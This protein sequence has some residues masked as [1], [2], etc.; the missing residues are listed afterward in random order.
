MRRDDFIRSPAIA[1]AFE[2]VPRHLFLPDLPLEQAYQ[3][4]AIPTR[5][6]ATG[7]VI[8]SSSQPQIMALMLEQLDLQP[9]HRV[10]EIGAGTGYNAA[11]MAYLAGE[12]GRVVTVDLDEEIVE[13]A[14]A[15]LAATGYTNVGLYCGDGWEGLAQE[16]PYDRIIVTASSMDIAPAWHDQLAP[17]GRIVLPLHLTSTTTACA[18]FDIRE[19]HLSSISLAYC[20]F[21][22]LRGELAPQLEVQEVTLEPLPGLT[23]VSSAPLPVPP[24][25][26]YEWLREGCSHQPTSVQTSFQT[27][28]A[29]LSLWVALHE[30]GAWVG[31]GTGEAMNSKLV[32]WLARHEGE[33]SISLTWG[34]VEEEGLALVALPPAAPPLQLFGAGTEP[35]MLWVYSCGPDSRVGQ[36]L[37]RQIMAWDAAGQPGLE[38]LMIRAY[39]RAAPLDVAP[40]AVIVE[41]PAHRF[42]LEWSS[43]T[44]GGTGEPIDNS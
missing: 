10:L 33:P 11:L 36:R 6:S 3:N 28:W 30:S 32:P 27:M 43:G 38:H 29:N 8:S 44:P 42:L 31:R 21:M 1:A 4:Q 14:R 22:R 25:V 16:A 41:R 2:T 39:P 18:A 24:T 5:R 7:E 19:D 13:S 35:F 9:G 17:G 12:S 34:I 23:L 26:L 37:A 40:D 15:H 20:G